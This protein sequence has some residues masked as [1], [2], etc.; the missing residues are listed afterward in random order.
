MSIVNTWDWST[1]RPAEETEERDPVKCKNCNHEFEPFEHFVS[2]NN[3]IG[4]KAFM[5]ESCFFDLA[6]TKFG[7]REVQMCSNGRD[8]HDYP[9]NNDLEYWNE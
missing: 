5:C 4:E 1:V 2:S 6:L 3:V 9:D 7:Y 8:Y